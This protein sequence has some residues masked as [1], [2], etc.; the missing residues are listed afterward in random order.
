MKCLLIF[1]P[2]SALKNSSVILIRNAAKVNTHRVQNIKDGVSSFITDLFLKTERAL[3]DLTNLAVLYAF[4][5]IY[6]TLGV[7]QSMQSTELL[8]LKVIVCL[9]EVCWLIM[10]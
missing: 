9:K 3:T 6:N 1:F 7:P 2:L 8:V 10:I 4:Y 5:C